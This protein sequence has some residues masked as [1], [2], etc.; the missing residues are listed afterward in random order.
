MTSAMKGGDILR[1]SCG[2][3]QTCGNIMRGNAM[4]NAG[5]EGL[6]QQVGGE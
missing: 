4:V 3:I 1:T 6:I 5:R 2:G